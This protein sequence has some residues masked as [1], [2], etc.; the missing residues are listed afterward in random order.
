LKRELIQIIETNSG[1]V[2]MLWHGNGLMRLLKELL[3]RVH[4]HPKWPSQEDRPIQPDVGFSVA[5]HRMAS[6]TP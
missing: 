2:A 4:A 6:R 1:R 5:S 3:I